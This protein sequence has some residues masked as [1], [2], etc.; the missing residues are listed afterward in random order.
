MPETSKLGGKKL[1]IGPTRG[2][3]DKMALYVNLTN[4]E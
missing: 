3:I 4:K 1:V 2:L